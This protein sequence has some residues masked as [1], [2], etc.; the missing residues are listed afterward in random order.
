MVDDCAF[1]VLTLCQ[2][3]D[4]SNHP[5]S[6]CVVLLQPT[7]AAK[8]AAASVPA[9][10][11]AGGRVR[12]KPEPGSAATQEAPSTSARTRE[13]REPKHAGG[14]RDG[15][16]VRQNLLD[17]DWEEDLEDET[18]QLSEQ[19]SPPAASACMCALTLWPRTLME[20]VSLALVNSCSCTC[21]SSKICLIMCSLQ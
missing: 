1:D 9:A 10:T 7:R 20:D 15:Y 5:D 16:A 6:Q 13:P 19:L 18:D 2:A 3:V 8:A 21:T 17:D 4:F 12:V 14:G 11:P